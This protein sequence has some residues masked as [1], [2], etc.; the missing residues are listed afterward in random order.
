MRLRKRVCGWQVAARGLCR[1]ISWGGRT[2]V[3]SSYLVPRLIITALLACAFSVTAG[4]GTFAAF[5]ARSDRSVSSARV[6]FESTKLGA[7]E[8]KA[9][10]AAD[11]RHGLP[12]GVR[13]PGW[14]L[15]PHQHPYF[16]PSPAVLKARQKTPRPRAT[17]A[18]HGTAAFQVEDEDLMK[19]PSGSNDPLGELGKGELGPSNDLGIRFDEVPPVRYLGGVVQHEPVVDVIFWGS[20][21]SKSPG[22]AVRTQLMK[23]YEGLSGSA[24][25]GV[26]TQYFD[27]TGRISSTVKVKSKTDERAAAPTS[28]NAASIASEI[29]Y[30]EKEWG[31][32]H[33]LETQ[34][35]VI[36]AP[37]STYESSFT[38]GFCAF[39]DVDSEGAI[40][41]FVPYAGDE[42]FNEREFC[43]SYYGRG[44][45]ADATNVMASH[46]YSESA[47]DPLWDTSPGWR[48]FASSEGEVA[49]LCATPG[50][51]LPNGSWVQGWY[52]DHQNACSESDEHPPHVLGLTETATKL[53][54]QEAT[55]NA[56]INPEGLATT[57][58][59]EYGA[60]TSY[61]SRVPAGE[62]SVGSGQENVSVSQPISSLTLENVYHYR[63]V[64]TNS[65]GT[66]YGEDRTVIPSDWEV[67]TPAPGAE[68]G[69]D[70]LNGVSCGSD[71][72]CMT[73][74]YYYDRGLPEPNRA[75]SYELSGGEWIQRAIPWNEGEKD[76]E[77]GGVSCT[78]PSACTAVG[79]IRVAGKSE[80]LLVRWNGS[81]WS[82]Q[83]LTPPAG[84]LG[85]E[86]YGVA[87]MT[88]TECVA[89]G[90]QR[91]RPK[92]G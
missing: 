78:A 71:T 15:K 73:V 20:N 40:Y 33:N 10:V 32:A 84:T 51:E 55:L 2:P 57:Y 13:V 80:P 81:S 62:V 67:R 54:E 42:P 36:T 86:L 5:A 39:H 88:E 64:A 61:G 1:K 76:G 24:E 38:G 69:E 31:W 28:V 22:S 23:F 21:W 83:A 3:A 8:Q 82:K 72:S 58:H 48:N 18:H 50:D 87:C 17:Q 9:L 91:T 60:T 11:R 4:I 34:Y 49:D 79:E 77:L 16:A 14:A 19:E 74:G 26:L 45:A 65:N 53:A 92:C 27:S 70:W 37:G 30:A 68:W 25:Q 89:V 85:V 59:F 12:S 90:T 46:E 41:S 63:V 29:Q 56:T 44:S 52:D 75:L 66:T 6:A 7:S 43:T 35:E 47:T